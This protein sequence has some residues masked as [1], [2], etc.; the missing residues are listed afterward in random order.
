VQL[1]SCRA[2]CLITA[3]RKDVCSNLKTEEVY[4][5]SLTFWSYLAIR[6]FIG[7]IGGTAFAMFEGAVIAILREQSADYGL[8]RVYANIG[9]MISSPLSGLLIDYAS[10]GK[11]Y[12]DF[13]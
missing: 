9:G 3:P 1:S 4:D 12:T 5:I 11:V 10:R 6:V 13:R 7:M 2:R 8:Q